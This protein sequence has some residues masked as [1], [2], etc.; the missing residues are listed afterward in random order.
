MRGGGSTANGGKGGGASIRIRRERESH[1]ARAEAKQKKKKMHYGRESS[2]EVGLLDARTYLYSRDTKCRFS[3]V[4]E[5][6]GNQGTFSR[7]NHK[8]R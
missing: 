2:I 7:N 5:N 3:T 1:K 8:Q 4:R 6:L